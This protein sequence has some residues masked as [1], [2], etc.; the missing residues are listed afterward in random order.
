M[1][2]VPATTAPT[3]TP[4]GTPTTTAPLPDR[5]S[6]ELPLPVVRWLEVGWPT[7]TDEVES[8][9]LSGPLRIRRNR[10]WMPGDGTMRFQ[11]GVGY[12]SDLRIGLGP[13]TAIRGLDAYVDG[14]GITRV[15]RQTDTGREIDQGAFLAL[16]AQSLLFPTAWARLPG[17]RWLAVDDTRAL[18]ALPFAG[19]TETG[20]VHFDPDGP[21]FPVAFEADRYKV[22]GGSKVRW[23]ADYGEWHW[24]D[25]LALPTR[26]VVTWAGDA[27][28]WFDM[29]IESMTPNAEVLPQ[30]D[31][32][33]EA[34]AA[35]REARRSP[36]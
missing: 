27:G 28:P 10:L 30:F 9:E 34:I 35:V 2:A 26:M 3:E 18:V 1:T 21:A 29:R 11:L 6:S 20:F 19:G 15:G 17:L 32:A 33:R 36:A 22:V 12:V 14:T 23:R 25:G 31:R 13:L 24:R 8:L 16:W 5:T 7:G 4:A